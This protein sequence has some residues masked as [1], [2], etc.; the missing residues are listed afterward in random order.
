MFYNLHADLTVERLQLATLHCT[1]TLCSALTEPFWL[2]WDEDV[3]THQLG[4]SQSFGESDYHLQADLT[5]ERL[6]LVAQPQRTTDTLLSDL[7]WLICHMGCST[8]GESQK[9][10]NN[11]LTDLTI[12]RQISQLLA[13]RL[14]HTTDTLLAELWPRPVSSP[15]SRRQDTQSTSS[16]LCRASQNA[17]DTVHLP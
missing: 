2:V 5:A 6:Q 15:S 16:L 10:T 17:K 1:D 9:Q 8:M 7:F 13:A 4:E 14:Q 3:Q 12:F 11:L